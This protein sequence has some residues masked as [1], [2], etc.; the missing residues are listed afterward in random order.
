M[1][2]PLLVLLPVLSAPVLAD[3]L[4]DQAN[5]LIA[6]GKAADAARLLE[7]LEEQRAGDPDFDYLLGLSRLESG[8][9]TEASFAFERCLGT[10]PMNGPCRVQMARAHLAMGETAN[11]RAELDIIQSHNPPPEV[12]ALV[13]QFLGAAAAQDRRRKSG[14]NGYTQLGLGFDT[15]LNSITDRNRIALPA[16]NN[17]P[18]ILAPGSRQQDGAVLQG[19]AGVNGYRML[20]PALTALGEASLQFHSYPGSSDFSWQTADAAGGL[21]RRA[22]A[23]Q[24]TAKVQLQDMRLGGNAYRRSAGLLGQYDHD[25]GGQDRMA[26]YAQFGHQT[27]DTLKNRNSNRFTLGAAWSGG[28]SLLGSPVVYA[29]AYAGQEKAGDSTAD[30]MASQ[31]FLG[32]RGGGSLALTPVWKLNGSLS[33]EQ[34]RYGAADPAFLK[35]R[36]DDEANL[37]LGLAW[38][39]SPAVTVLPAYNYTRNSSNIP[40]TDYDRNVVTVDVRYDW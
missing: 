17:A 39:Y 23:D 8:L 3:A 21:A 38:Q 24:L 2:L 34:R 25:L 12:Q 5:Q 7:P 27:Y 16:F 29:G 1:R 13:Q 40:L 18:F 31:K 26:V 4:L 32:V 20:N 14:Y 33:V 10:D 22:G 11:A 37:S 19:Q 35:T 36:R 6:A 15:N 28:L 9:P 30:Y